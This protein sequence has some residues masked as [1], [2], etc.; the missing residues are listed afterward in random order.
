M[1]ILSL[2]EVH[3]LRSA[4]ITADLTNSRNALLVGI[5]SDF[6]ASLPREAKAGEQVL[7]DLDALNTAGALADRSMPILTWL[8]NAVALAGPRAEALVFRRLLE[9]P[10]GLARPHARLLLAAS[11][12]VAQETTTL[13][14]HHR[15]D[16]PL[17]RCFAGWLGQ[18]ADQIHHHPTRLQV[19]AHYYQGCLS[20]LQGVADLS[21]RAIADLSDTTE[22]FWLEA[23]PLK[24]T[25]S[26][27]IFLVN[28][29]VMFDNNRL[30]N[31]LR[32]LR[33][34]S[35]RYPVKVH[36]VR[37][38]PPNEPHVFGPEG[39]SR[40]LLL[41]KPNLVGGYVKRDRDIFLRIQSDD[42]VYR[43]AEVQYARISERALPFDP[44]WD[45]T[46]LRQSWMVK[47]RIGRWDTG[48]GDIRD[49]S[50]DYFDRY[51]LHI[52]CW[53]PE[54]ERF[55]AH[56]VKLV[57]VEIARILRGTKDSIRV[58]EIGCGTGALTVQLVEWIQNM[59]R[60]F[61]DLREPPPI[62][63]FIAVDR[64]PY[65]VGLTRAALGHVTKD[66]IH[67]CEDNAPL[68]F[69]PDVAQHRPFHVICGSL[70]L[71]D[72][73]DADPLQSA[74][75]LLRKLSGELASGGYLIF[76]DSF[77]FG[78]PKEREKQLHA[79]RQ[80][81]VASGMHRNQIEE[82]LNHNNEMVETITLDDLEQIAPKHGF[83]SPRVLPMPG[84]R[85]DSP[86]GVLVMTKH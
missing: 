48:W 37:A 32:L 84:G 11:E 77:F 31:L 17:L 61:V 50:G 65:M 81:M 60:P 29:K 86:F 36:H 75:H 23:D 41:M 39:F 12:R 13:V 2:D 62:E 58:L 66:R 63:R 30:D 44:K 73:L 20:Q 40:N 25:A 24:T 54:Y 49:R 21:V 26:E 7:R 15:D 34:H 5:P 3:E 28:W 55:V 18:V 8:T 43:E 46:T 6:V 53:I 47:N 74:D 35:E 57:E 85:V 68:F 69:S 80:A 83:S 22:T 59:N 9:R 71:H 52:R 16:H 4:V 10:A 51:D 56:C 67:V 45:R 1:G 64:S 38:S 72:L 70:V 14:A 33:E 27:R 79:W 78:S 76:A 42:R 82:F 19:D